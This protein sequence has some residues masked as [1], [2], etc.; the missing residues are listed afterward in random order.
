MPQWRN[1]CRDCVLGT[2]TRSSSPSSQGT[3]YLDPRRK[4]NV[5]TGKYLCRTAYPAFRGTRP[6]G[7]SIRFLYSFVR[8]HSFSRRDGV[9][10][11]CP[12]SHLNRGWG[13]A[14]EVGVYVSL[15]E[16]SHSCPN[17]NGFSSPLPP[18]II[19]NNYLLSTS[20]TFVFVV[21]F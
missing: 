17:F 9:R 20:Q 19:N 15:W 10:C 6:L 7:L 18:L 11:C 13:L 12:K 4:N 21:F 1:V 8:K 16:P 2:L 14:Q 3:Q 5:R